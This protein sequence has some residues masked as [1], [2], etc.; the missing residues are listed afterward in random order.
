MTKSEIE[1]K[2]A[3]YHRCIGETVT[4]NHIVADPV[5][6]FPFVRELTNLIL[7]ESTQSVSEGDVEKVMR[8]AFNEV[9]DDYAPKQ[10]NGSIERKI[11]LVVGA[12]IIAKT[13]S[14]LQST[15]DSREVKE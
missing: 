3:K 4:R 5:Y 6:M 7:S 10:P 1:N 8:D 13:L 12:T 15:K 9:L 14:Y 2:I 11:G